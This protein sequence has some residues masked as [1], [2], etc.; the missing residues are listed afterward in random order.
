MSDEEKDLMY[1]TEDLVYMVRL[2]SNEDKAK[3][4]ALMS[5]EEFLALMEFKHRIKL[6]STVL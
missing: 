2:V 6:Y 3:I 1:N 5:D 4:E